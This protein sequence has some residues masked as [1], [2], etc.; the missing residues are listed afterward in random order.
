V[1]ILYTDVPIEAQAKLA[2]ALLI[3][4]GE[5]VALSQIIVPILRWWARDEIEMER[6]LEL[7]R[8]QG[9]EETRVGETTE[10]NGV[11]LGPAEQHTD[12][13]KTVGSTPATVV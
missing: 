7:E 12:E 4:N 13:E 1:T 10:G 9:Q 2:L 11:G 3:Y 8:S 5:H 6:Q